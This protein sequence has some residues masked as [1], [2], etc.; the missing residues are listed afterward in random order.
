[1][2]IY[3]PAVI[4][5]FATDLVYC[6]RWMRNP[7]LAYGYLRA[8]RLPQMG[9]FKIGA[10]EC[11]ARKEDWLAMREVFIE[12]EYQAVDQLFPVNTAP[13]VLDLG[14]NI[15]CFALRVFR[16]YPNA[17]VI[18]L[19]AAD[20]TFKVLDNN[21]TVNAA[22]NWETLN[23]AVWGEDKEVSLLRRGISVSHQVI[24]GAGEETVQ[25]ISLDMLLNKL[26]WDGVDLI[27][28]DIEGGE[29]SVIPGA[30]DVLRRTRFLIIE[31]HN[32]R[33]DSSPVLATLKSA[34]SSQWQINDRASKKPLYIM[35]NEPVNPGTG[36]VRVD[37]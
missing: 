27:K 7:Y 23:L 15:G 36:A 35:A 11:Q 34:F 18:S 25:G 17:Q 32:D 24:D 2:K 12:D 26:D 28:M 5:R 1:M 29:E 9:N 16:S 8:G 30:L 31:I 13:K 10:C 14:A 21:R 6:V 22:L 3:S 19:E 33:I 20:D 37:I 4:W